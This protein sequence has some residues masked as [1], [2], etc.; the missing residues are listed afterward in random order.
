MRRWMRH[1]A[2]VPKGFLRYKALKLLNE[3]PMSGSEIMNWIEEQ[4]DGN[5]RPSPGSIYPL[6]AWLQDNGYVREADNEAGIKRYTLTDKGK[7]FLEEHERA[8]ERLSERF[9][10]FGPGPGF[11]GPPWGEFFPDKAA[12]K[13]RKPAIGLAMSLWAFHGVLSRSY[14]EEAVEEAGRALEEAS[15]KI[16]EITRNLEGS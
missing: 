6:L 4:T 16:E 13:L 5:W 1:M 14:S 12:A 2:M 7:A 9:A 3:K 15:K 8:Q 11:M 10:H